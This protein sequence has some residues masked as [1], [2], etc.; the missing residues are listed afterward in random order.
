MCVSR[1]LLHFRWGTWYHMEVDVVCTTT[2]TTNVVA[3]KAMMEGVGKPWPSPRRMANI[4]VWARGRWLTFEVVWIGLKNPELPSIKEAWASLVELDQ[5]SSKYLF[6]FHSFG[7]ESM[8]LFSM[9]GWGW[10]EWFRSSWKVEF[11]RTS[12]IQFSYDP[13]PCV[14]LK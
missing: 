13:R 7:C 6:Y 2:L 14:D 11:D 8:N 12:L 10:L 1:L 3:V 5:F 9:F 4:C